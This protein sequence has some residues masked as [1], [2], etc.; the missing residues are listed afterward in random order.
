MNQGVKVDR[1]KWGSEE[2]I[3]LVSA[4]S[5]FLNTLIT[6][7]VAYLMR[8]ERYFPGFQDLCNDEH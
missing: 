5:S 4:M 2:K 7:G 1:G 3:V 8:F 6:N